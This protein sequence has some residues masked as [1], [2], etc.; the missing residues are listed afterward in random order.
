MVAG[1]VMFEVFASFILMLSAAGLLGT[2]GA[3]GPLAINVVLVGF[4][5]LVGLPAGLC[6]RHP[7]L[8]LPA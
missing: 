8:H 5:L 3:I 2:V 1:H 7:D 4:E 6:V